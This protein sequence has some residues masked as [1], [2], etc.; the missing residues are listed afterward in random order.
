MCSATGTCQSTS[1]SSQLMS[2]WGF[3]SGTS[4][5]EPACRC[6]RHERC[7]FDPWV[8]KIPWRRAWHPTPVFFPEESCGERSLKDYS[9]WGHEEWDTSEVSEHTDTHTMSQFWYIIINWTPPIILISLVF[10]SF[11]FAAPES[12]GGPYMTLSC[13]VSLDSSWLRQCLEF[14]QFLM[15]F[16]RGAGG[17]FVRYPWHLGDRFGGG[18]LIVSLQ[19]QALNATLLLMRGLSLDSD[20]PP[21]PFYNGL[22]EQV[23]SSCPDFRAGELKGHLHEFSGVTNIHVAL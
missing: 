15:T 21:P 18:L 12:P 14:F 9:P 16:F 13:H 10:H 2:Q 7:R 5:K 23:P 8:E 3:P 17:C 22:W 4:G 1:N 20:S 6:R 11:P 19:F